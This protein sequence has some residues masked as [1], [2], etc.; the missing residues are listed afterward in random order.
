VRKKQSPAEGALQKARLL[1]FVSTIIW[2]EIIC[3]RFLGYEEE[4]G[5]GQDGG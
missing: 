1:F 4:K 3:I 5:E 2:G